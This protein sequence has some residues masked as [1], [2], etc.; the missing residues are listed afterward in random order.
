MLTWLDGRNGSSYSATSWAGNTLSFT[1]NVGAGANGLT[2]MV[3]THG[4]GGTPLTGLTL[5]GSPVSFTKTT[6]KGVEYAMFLAA[7]GGYAATYGAPPAAPA[8]LGGANVQPLTA[9][10]AAQD[11]ASI[12]PSA[13][14]APDQTA[15]V[16]SQVAA[17][18]LPDGTAQVTWSTDE[19]ADA[20]LQIGPQPNS[21]AELYDDTRDTTHTVVATKLQP[22][23]TYHYRVKSVDPAGNATVWPAP[24]D[25][26]ATF[27]AAANGVAD[28]TAQQF[29][30]VSSQSGTYVQ[31]DNLGE[32]SLAP[33]AATEFDTA[34][35]PSTWDQQQ[36]ST[37]GRTVLRRG[38]L[39]L[40]GARAGTKAQF[41]P[42]RSLVFR[43]TFAG[44]GTQWAGL[45]AGTATDR[46]Q[47]SGC[48]TAPC[49][50]P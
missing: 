4:P 19:D 39:V 25:P 16:I 45:A 47:C 40:D 46:G 13:A 2:G 26:P 3:P 22:G 5:A 38:N 7:P 14:A 44:P 12:A 35:L 34:A 24:T 15:P 8:A 49:T 28:L 42:G 37:G 41:G 33:A 32:V 6:I 10:A 20:T 27:V 50:P 29:R 30:T 18:P 23:A 11:L 17:R 43:A 48:G 21:L 31:Q 1:V 36:E 9:A